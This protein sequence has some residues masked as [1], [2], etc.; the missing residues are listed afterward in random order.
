MNYTKY[1]LLFLLITGCDTKLTQEQKQKI[2][3]TRTKISCLTPDGWVD[4]YTIEGEAFWRGGWSFHNL[5]GDKIQSS[6]CQRVFKLKTR[7]VK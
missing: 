7:K 6:M 1:L 3:R 2:R 5:E 4:H